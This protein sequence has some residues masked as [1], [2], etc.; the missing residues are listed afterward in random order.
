M[1]AL[2]RP[3]DFYEAHYEKAKTIAINYLKNGL[4]TFKLKATVLSKVHPYAVGFIFEK[5]GKKVRFP[6]FNWTTDSV[7]PSM[8]VS[9]IF[10]FWQNAARDIRERLTRVALLYVHS[11]R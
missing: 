6:M 5:V 7:P 1:S 2:A 8:N 3:F 10:L 11:S 9:N 4:T